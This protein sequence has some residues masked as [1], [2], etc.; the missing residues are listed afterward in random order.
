MAIALDYTQ[1][2]DPAALKAAD[3]SDVCRYLSWLYQ[4][5]GVT[6]DHP[7]PKIIQQREYDELVRAGIGVQR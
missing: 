4:W 3:V 5:G 1:R 7:N 6:H 2:I